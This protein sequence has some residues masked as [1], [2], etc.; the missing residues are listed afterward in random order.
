MK[1]IESNIPDGK[2]LFIL[3]LCTFS[4]LFGLFAPKVYCSDSEPLNETRVTGSLADDLY[5]NGGMD[6]KDTRMVPDPLY[7]VN[8][9]MYTF[10]DVL[11]FVILKPVATGYKLITPHPVRRGLFNFFHNLMFPVRFVNNLLQGKISN[12]GNE[13]RIFLVNSTAGLLGLMTPAQDHFELK[14]SNEDFGQTLGHFKIKE[15]IYLVLPVIGSSTL[16]DAAG[17]VPDAFLNPLFYVDPAELSTGMRAV[18]I[19]NGT[20]FRLGDY[21]ALKKAAVD[22]YQA[23]KHAYIQNRVYMVNQ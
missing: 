12:A 11:Y 2:K 22:P 9:V 8:Y 4:I 1:I 18:D 20:S 7:Y 10:N 17:K 21:E 14:T 23:L 6:S 16:R 13:A 15:G 3:V 5:G 19:I